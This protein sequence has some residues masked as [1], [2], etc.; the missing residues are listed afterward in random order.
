M[1]FRPPIFLGS[2]LILLVVIYLGK[3]A[4][5]EGKFLLG[6]AIASLAAYL[7]L[8]Y[9]LLLFTSLSIFTFLGTAL[10]WTWIAASGI[11]LERKV[12]KEAMAG[13]NVP[14]DYSVTNRSFL[15]LYHARIW[16]RAYRIRSDE[17]QDEISFEQPGYVGFLKIDRREKSEGI[18][19][20]VPPVRGRMHFGPTAI[21]GGDPFGI[22]QT[23]NW[24]PLTDDCLVLPSWVRMN[25]LPAIPARLGAKEQE[26]LVGREGHSHEFLGIRPWTEGDSLRGVHWGLTA[27]HN[28]LI[29]RQFQKE[30]EE[31]LLIILDADRDG[32]VGDGPENAFEYLI[33][34]SLSLVNAAIETAR[35]WSL[36]IVDRKIKTLTYNTK[37]SLRQAQYV[38]GDLQARREEPLE[39]LLDGIRAGY[40]NAACILLTPRTDNVV[41]ETLSAGDTQIGGGVRSIL[42]RVDPDS[43]ASSVGSGLKSRKK[44][45]GR[46]EERTVPVKGGWS[47]LPE[48]TVSQGDNLSDLFAGVVI[49]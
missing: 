26:H 44:R 32:D 21:E 46:S 6:T 16:D 24:M 49:A 9:Y 40:P 42:I 37:E 34:L 17:S 29:V 15:P 4:S 31:E 2:L 18:L 19:H 3:R 23:V 28:A 8:H 30:V 14:V 36:V 41:A 13:E 48:I 7:H 27:K 43:F 25:V 45:R 35:P 5:I 39:E 38:L 12:K 10:V 33:T 11:A 20:I 47:R 1:T 22:F